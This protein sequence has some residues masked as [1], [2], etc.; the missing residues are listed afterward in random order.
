MLELTW[1]YGWRTLQLQAQI[2]CRLIWSV[3]MELL[4]LEIKEQ[5]VATIDHSLLSQCLST[6]L[7]RWK[8]FLLYKIEKALCPPDMGY[9]VRSAETK[10]TSLADSIFL[11]I[12]IGFKI[13]LLIHRH[14]CPF[15]KGYLYSH[16]S[17][18]PFSQGQNILS[19]LQPPTGIKLKLQLASRWSL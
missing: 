8:Q 4:L 18:Q 19:S 12:Y 5:K 10:Y 3:R 9:I 17:S 1:Q 14:I 15:S 7:S 2:K 6:V 11:Q 13:S 16:D